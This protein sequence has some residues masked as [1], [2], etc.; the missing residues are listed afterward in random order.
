MPVKTLAPQISFG[1][2]SMVSLTDYHKDF[3]VG[4]SALNPAVLA[5]E[6]FDSWI[7]PGQMT[8]YAL[9]GQL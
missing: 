7:R 9:G 5:A 6:Q 4:Q 1:N 8:T 2:V 3:A